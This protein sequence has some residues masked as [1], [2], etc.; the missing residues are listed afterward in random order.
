MN[1]GVQKPPADMGKTEAKGTTVS[2]I[3]GQSPEQIES[4]LR[5]L[6]YLVLNKEKMTPEDYQK[7][8]SDP[9][10]KTEQ[11]KKSLFELLKSDEGLRQ[12]L[13]GQL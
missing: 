11:T 3:M 13:F 5:F 12:S 2:G 4:L 1:G 8:S 9:E 10:S 6:I 7:G